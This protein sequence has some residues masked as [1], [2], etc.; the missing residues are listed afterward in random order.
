MRAIVLRIPEYESLRGS[1]GI[2]DRSDRGVVRLDGADRRSFLQGLLTNDIQALAPGAA[3]YAALLTPQGRMIA[4]MN[5]LET[6]EFLLLDVRRDQAAALTAKFEQ[7][8]FTEDVTVRDATAEYGRLAL[9]GPQAQRVLERALRADPRV[10]TRHFSDPAFNVPLIEVFAQAAAFVSLLDTL[11]DAGAVEV[12]RD[13]AEVVRVESGVPLF[14]V[15]MDEETIPLEAGIQDRAISFTKGCYVGQE[16]IVRVL[17]R[18]HG[19]VAKKLVQLEIEATSE[20]DLPAPGTAIQK[21]GTQAGT[22]T[23]VAWSPRL[24]KGVAL[25][26]VHRDYAEPGARFDNMVISSVSAGG[27]SS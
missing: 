25:G 7:S 9:G 14:G 11:R 16:V 17:H 12:G 1:A 8:I 3:C 21:D 10:S 24:G 22:L 4:D 20:A 5:V 27:H 13:A 15:D 26:Y 6:G 19:R 2:I 23:S 18:G